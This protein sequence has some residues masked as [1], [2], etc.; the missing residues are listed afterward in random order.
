MLSIIGYV[1]VSKSGGRGTLRGLA[2]V[3]LSVISMHRSSEVKS[4]MNFKIIS[5]KKVKGWQIALRK[6]SMADN[7]FTVKI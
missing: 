5:W 3:F 7:K 6:E 2:G 1:V 4:E